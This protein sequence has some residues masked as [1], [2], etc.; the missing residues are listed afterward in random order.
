MR[1]PRVGSAV[2]VADSGRVLLGRRA[3]DPNRGKWVLPGG[4]VRPFESIADA[5]RREALEETGL[6]IEIERVLGVRE[7]IDDPNEHRLIVY[8]TAHPIGGGLRADSDLDDVRWFSRGELVHLDL[9]DVVRSVLDD[10]GWILPI[11]A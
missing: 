3:K 7:I 6:E 11:A 4:K 1:V 8:S 2:L 10:Q 9:S 5:A